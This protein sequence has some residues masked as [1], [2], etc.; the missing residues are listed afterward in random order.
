MFSE[1][2]LSCEAIPS[3]EQVV[4]EVKQIVAESSG[5]PLEQIQESTTLL[6]NLPW[7]SLDLVEC[8]ME[9]EEQFNISISDE[10]IDEAKTINDI[11]D[12]VLA[13]LTQ[14]PGEKKVAVT[15]IGEA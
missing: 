12:G 13:L 9:I 11:V 4:K 15:K 6:R 10:L 1:N 5:V 3:R 7:D 8:T 2:K 14:P